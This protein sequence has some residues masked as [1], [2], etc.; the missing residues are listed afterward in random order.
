MLEVVGDEVTDVGCAGAEYDN[1]G[2]E[3][4]LGFWTVLHVAEDE[5]CAD[6]HGQGKGGDKA[7][8]KNWA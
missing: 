6:D 7:E 3:V 2:Q 1:G 4:D 5:A 8:I